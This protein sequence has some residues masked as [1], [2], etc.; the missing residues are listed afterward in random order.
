MTTS[1][2]FNAESMSKILQFLWIITFN[3]AVGWLISGGLRKVVDL[4]RVEVATQTV[5]HRHSELFAEAMRRAESVIRCVR[6]I[7]RNVFVLVAFPLFRCL[8]LGA[9]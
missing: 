1:L 9:I 2:S 5:W 8:F 6:S 7:A 3:Y 4:N